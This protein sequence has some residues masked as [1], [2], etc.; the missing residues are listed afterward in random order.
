MDRDRVP[1]L[2][3]PA[4]CKSALFAA[5][6]MLPTAAPAQDRTL[7]MEVVREFLAL[8]LAG[9]RLP[10]P[11]EACLTELSLRRLEPM[12]FGSTEMIDQPE[13]VDPPGPHYRIVRIEPEGGDRRRRLARVEWLLPGADGTPKVEPDSFVFVVNDA[14][15]DRGTAS[16]VRE[17]ARLVVRRECFG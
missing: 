8:E 14:V 12:A 4:V 17:P 11:V 2:S 16:M 5:A 3:R 10:D 15:G 1:V 13:L 7:E 6:L 9:W